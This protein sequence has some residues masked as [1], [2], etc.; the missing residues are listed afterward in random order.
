MNYS[1]FI[2]S[3]SKMSESHGFIIDAGMDKAIAALAG[4]AMLQALNK[5]AKEDLQRERA[6]S[7]N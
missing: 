5:K 2:N 7:V 1:A 3:K 6:K 4:F